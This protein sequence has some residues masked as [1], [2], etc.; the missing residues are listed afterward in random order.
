MFLQMFK[1]KFFVICSAIVI[2]LFILCACNQDTQTSLFV[3]EEQEQGF[4]MFTGGTDNV[5]IGDLYYKSS[6]KE[7]EKI[8]ENVKKN[9]YLLFPN[10]QAVL[11]LD[12]SGVLYYKAQG[13]EKEKISDRVLDSSFSFSSDEQTVAFITKNDENNE[14]P[15]ELYIKKLNSEKEKI[16][17]DM[18]NESGRHSYSL[19]GDGSIIFYINKDNVLYKKS[20]QSDKEKIGSEVTNFSINTSGTAYTYVTSSNN[21]YVKWANDTEAQK[22]SSEAVGNMSISQ[23]G[24]I[25]AFTGSYN[26]EKG[27]GELYVVIRNSDAIKIASDVKNFRLS[28]DGRSLYY[29]NDEGTV[30]LKKLP[31]VNENTYLNQAKFLDKL[32]KETKTMLCSDVVQYEISA[33]GKHAVFIDTDKNLYLS[34][35][36]QEKVRFASDVETAKIFP[37]RLLFLNKEKQLVLNSIISEVSKAQENNK[38]IAQ[39]VL[40]FATSP[41]GRYIVFSTDEN[42]SV[43]LCSDGQKPET[44]IETVDNFDIIAY[45]GNMIYEKKLKMS[46][47]IGMYKNEALGL[48]YKIAEDGV[49]DI[50]QD[51][52]TKESKKTNVNG[53]NKYTA[54][55]V[56]AEADENSEFSKNYY[57][58]VVKADGSKFIKISGTE[59]ALTTLDEAGLNAEL[60]R[61]KK[62]KEKREAEEARRIA[63]EKRKAEIAERKSAAAARGKNYM[64]DGIY[65]Y[66]YQTLYYSPSYSDASSYYFSYGGYK[67]V[68]DYQVSSDG[69][70]L[71]LEIYGG[72]YGYFWVVE[73]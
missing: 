3:D 59:Y 67:N 68:Y 48:A 26:Y 57:Q 20:G 25:A 27:L 50:Y 6:G 2:V 14:T 22:V 56:L 52:A 46:D 19:S 42:A 72:S 41:Y 32:N 49:F 45:R 7:K 15:T 38:I 55:I 64:Q 47:V 51:G 16:T 34:Y 65:V 30:Y 31:A 61:Q 9:Q 66:P 69:S 40:N 53:I 10:S 4:L 60:E 71:W 5:D 21:Y 29:L 54:E 23:E 12:Q 18:S 11:F 62:E 24:L 63:E 28:Y 1:R 17:S 33:D 43:Q 37:S 39:K 70:T 13:S 44:V 8:G 73:P 58:F 36:Q 35:N